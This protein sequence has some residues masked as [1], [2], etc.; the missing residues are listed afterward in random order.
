MIEQASQKGF[1]LGDLIE[2]D[3]L[4]GLV[5]LLDGAGAADDGRDAGSW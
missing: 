4:V 2:V 1:A 5:R 3:E